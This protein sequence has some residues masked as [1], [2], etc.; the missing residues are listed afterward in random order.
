MQI[1]SQRDAEGRRPDRPDTHV[2]RLMRRTAANE[3]AFFLPHL[4]PGM[5]VLDCGCGPGTI[6]VGVAEQV[7]PG[8]VVGIDPDAGRL[9]HARA[10]ASERGLSNVRFEQGDI[11][12]LPFPDASFDAALVHAV[13]EHLRD[14]VAALRQVR[15]VLKSGGVVGVRD[16]EHSIDV[17]APSNPVVD[18]ISALY[19]RLRVHDGI[20]PQLGRSVRALVRAAGFS[21]VVGSAS[22]ETCG[23]PEETRVISAEGV[24][25]LH[26]YIHKAVDLGWIDEASFDHMVE[27]MRAWGDNP[28][29]FRAMPW[30]EAIGWAD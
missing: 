10:L 15:R 24:E 28:D 26:R 2:P 27:A 7:Q 8:E 14:P 11:Y 18:Q 3:L 13:L 9:E 22:F 20:D 23:T 16:S 4:S 12:A 19:S 17:V 29:A 21:R 1:S 25:F 5:R 30:F 6:T